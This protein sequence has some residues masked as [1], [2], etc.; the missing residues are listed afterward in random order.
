MTR[1]LSRFVVRC[2]VWFSVG[3]SGDVSDVSACTRPAELL[4]PLPPYISPQPMARTQGSCLTWC[5]LCSLAVVPPGLHLSCWTGLSFAT[6][7]YCR[8]SR[9]MLSLPSSVRHS[10]IARAAPLC[11]V[12]MLLFYSIEYR[13]QS[14]FIIQNKIY[15]PKLLLHPHLYCILIEHRFCFIFIHRFK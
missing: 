3:D 6:L 10:I 8:W 7:L 2:A 13:I 4:L 15:L 12:H 11:V 14:P 5:V 1:L 9:L